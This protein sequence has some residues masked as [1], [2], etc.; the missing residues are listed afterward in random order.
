MHERGGA[1]LCDLDERWS[2][3]DLREAHAALDVVDALTRK[4]RAAA[5]E[6]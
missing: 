3:D 5:R 4:A 6:P 2:L 1:T